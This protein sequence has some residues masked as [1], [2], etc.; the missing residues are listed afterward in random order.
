M[1]ITKQRTEWRD[2]RF[3]SV[4]INQIANLFFGEIFSQSGLAR[5]ALIVKEYNVVAADGG[6]RG[7]SARTAALSRKPGISSFLP[8]LLRHIQ[9]RHED[10]RAA[11]HR[12]P[13]F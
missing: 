9:C 4:E 6:D 1:T 2:Q 3:A 7:V 5:V 13:E 10:N 12:A 8:P 11:K